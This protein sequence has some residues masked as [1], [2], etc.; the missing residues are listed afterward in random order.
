MK[1][2]KQSAKRI[3][4]SA[5]RPELLEQASFI[6]EKCVDCPKCLSECAFL[7]KYGTP[8]QIAGAV[9]NEEL[10]CLTT[11]YECSLC[12]LCVR[13]CAEV[14]DANVAYFKGR[15]IDREVAV[16][17]DQASECLYCGKCFGL[18]TGGWIVNQCDNAVA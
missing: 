7:K 15:G 16:V 10:T 12:G 14:K 3:R 4:P 5:L 8:K 11:A 13:Y 6:H 18:C 1:T 2:S 17:S 9:M